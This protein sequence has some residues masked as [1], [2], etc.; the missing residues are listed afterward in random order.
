MQ[1]IYA[2]LQFVGKNKILLNLLAAG[3]PA[4]YDYYKRCQKKRAERKQQ[5]ALDKAKNENNTEDLQDELNKS[6]SD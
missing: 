2:L 5:E 4:L 1:A 6:L 3:L